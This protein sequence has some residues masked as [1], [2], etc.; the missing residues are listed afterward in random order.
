LV[1]HKTS[2]NHFCQSHGTIP[3]SGHIGADSLTKLTLSSTD[4]NKSSENRRNQNH[5]PHTERQK[6]P[7]CRYCGVEHDFIECKE[8]YPFYRPAE[9]KL[10]LSVGR[11]PSKR[12]KWPEKDTYLTKETPWIKGL[13]EKKNTSTTTSN[14][15]QATATA[16][17]AKTGT[18][19][20]NS[21]PQT[22]KK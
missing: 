20:S 7:K 19:N 9:V 15:N 8:K 16:Q 3:G 11:N 14:S 2:L 10:L 12:S 1:S 6:D 5:K 21:I 13:L 18:Q 4:A 17:T 22:Q